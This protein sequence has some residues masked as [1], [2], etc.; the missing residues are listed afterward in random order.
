MAGATGA[1]GTTE[2]TGPHDGQPSQ[3]DHNPQG[4]LDSHT[5]HEPHEESDDI[6]I[7][8]PSQNDE[9][10]GFT[11]VIPCSVSN[12]S[13]TLALDPVHPFLAMTHQKGLMISI[14]EISLDEKSKSRL[15]ETFG[16]HHRKITCVSFGE[17]SHHIRHVA[18]GD[19]SSNVKVHRIDFR[20]PNSAI[21]IGLLNNTSI[22]G[23]HL[24]DRSNSIVSIGWLGETMVSTNSNGEIWKIN[25]LKCEKWEI[26]TPIIQKSP[27]DL[28]AV[29]QTFLTSNVTNVIV[30]Q[31]SGF[32]AVSHRVSKISVV[33]IH[34]IIGD[35][36]SKSQYESSLYVNSM[37]FSRDASRLFLGCSKDIIVLRV[38]PNGNNMTPL[39]RHC[40]GHTRHISSVVFHVTSEGESVLLAGDLSGHVVLLKNV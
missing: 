13:S 11:E 7:V 14:Y 28:D 37:C 27:S 2:T 16:R 19:S 1:D 38:S 8:H 25:T 6:T 22:D 15:V 34:D 33:N 36:R 3:Q 30:H 12:G 26:T 4:R 23:F 40:F 18:S 17:I 35:C 24:E 39:L 9:S 20:V 21:C 5:P 32:S 31:S 10:V 29:R